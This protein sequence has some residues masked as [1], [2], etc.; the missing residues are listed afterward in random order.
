MHG[1]DVQRGL[2]ADRSGAASLQQRAGMHEMLVPGLLS[3]QI[4]AEIGHVSRVVCSFQRP[5]FMDACVRGEAIWHA[6]A[7]LAASHPSTP[8]RPP[9]WLRSDGQN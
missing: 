5:T 9:V 8:S 6:A 1:S 4:D 2:A 7:L 3:E